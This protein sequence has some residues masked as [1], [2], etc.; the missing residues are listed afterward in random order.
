METLRKAAAA[1]VFPA[2]ACLA[3]ACDGRS[4]TEPDLNATFSPGGSGNTRW[5][6]DDGVAVPPG[7]S[8][9]R[10][11]YTTI[12][13]AVNAANPGDRIRVCEGTYREQVRVPA[14]KNNIQLI[15][16]GLWKAVIKPPAV[17]VPDH[18]GANTIVHVDGAVNTTILAF[19]ISGPAPVLHYGVRVD[20]SGSANVL[21]NHITHVKT[22]PFNV[23]QNGAAVLIGGTT[24]GSGKVL[25]N[26]IDDYQQNGPTIS[27]A[28]SSG[29][30]S[31]NR[32]L[33][34]GASVLNAQNGIQIDRGAP[35]T[36]RHNFV[37]QNIYTGPEPLGA[38]GIYFSATSQVVSEH[39][40]VTAND[41]G[42][43]VEA[44]SGSSVKE[45]RIRASTYDGV[46]VFA[47]NNNQV[48]HTSSGPNS[49]S[50]VYMENAQQN[51]IFRNQIKDNKDS[52]FLLFNSDVNNVRANHLHS[53]GTETG[54]D[55]TD[56]IRIELGS[57]N[58]LADNKLK[59]NATHDCHDNSYPSNTWTNNRQGSSF[60]PLSELC[61]DDEDDQLEA[62]SSFGW[63]ASYPWY[64]EFS[65][66][67]DLDFAVGY[68]EFDLDSLLQLLPQI[69][70]DLGRPKPRP[71]R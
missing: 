19:T 30:V 5:V 4:P 7:Q 20:N 37:A 34:R 46:V 26:V 36:V 41:F 71:F 33:G 49:L 15:S 51:S 14:G 48:V 67:V 29:E 11:G 66:A 1:L 70:I 35:A 50:G 55:L 24:P 65:E 28:G 54:V 43:Y 2:V 18:D 22:D 53:N 23:A 45:S 56:G 31:Y 60:P 63:N 8:C 13:S 64:T 17:M 39:N 47:S 62:E 27:G 3:A 10:P 52:G 16:V 44:T 38:T 42:V 68:A 9:S 12:Q 59:H 6:N 25:G 61:G 32:V 21:G 57:G 69:R 40:T 58:T